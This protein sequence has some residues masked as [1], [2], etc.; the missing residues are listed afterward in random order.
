M[1]RRHRQAIGHPPIERTQHPL[2]R[3]HQESA[4]IILLYRC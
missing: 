4:I 3:S 2:P 1:M